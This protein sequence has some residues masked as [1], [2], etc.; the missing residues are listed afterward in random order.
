[1]GQGCGVDDFVAV[2]C[3]E[4]SSYLACVSHTQIGTMFMRNADKYYEERSPY[5]FALI[6]AL[7][8]ASLAKGTLKGEQET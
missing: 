2:S 4:T 5:F 8:A 7:A 6:A 1:M 3:S